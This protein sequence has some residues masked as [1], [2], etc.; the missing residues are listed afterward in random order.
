MR[1]RILLAF[2][3]SRS[4]V[5]SEPPHKGQIGSLPPVALARMAPHSIR[6]LAQPD[7]SSSSA[8]EHR[9]PS[10][11]AQQSKYKRNT[12]R[13]FFGDQKANLTIGKDGE[14]NAVLSHILGSFVLD[15]A[16]FH[17]MPQCPC[18]VLISISVLMRIS[19]VSQK[20]HDFRIVPISDVHSRA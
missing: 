20:L 6:R 17:Q 3:K 4:R 7:Q 15:Q 12:F 14:P 13:L 19:N 11:A 2:S 10:Q 1:F 8:G 18:R 5:R 16:P 9:Q